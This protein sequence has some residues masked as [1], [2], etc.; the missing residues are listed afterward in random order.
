MVV[1]TGRQEL[2]PPTD[3]ASIP[4]GGTAG[5]AGRWPQ[6]KLGTHSCQPSWPPQPKPNQFIFPGKVIVV[7][8]EMLI[9]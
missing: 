5:A 6:E 4:A 1:H 2:A 7:V 8:T 3:A 9:S